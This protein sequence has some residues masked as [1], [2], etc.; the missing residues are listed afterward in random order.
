MYT[1]I[2]NYVRY[3]YIQTYMLRCINTLHTYAVHNVWM[4]EQNVSLKINK[5]WKYI[6]VSKLYRVLMMESDN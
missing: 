6:H 4:G 5:F 2:H 3:I 1:Y